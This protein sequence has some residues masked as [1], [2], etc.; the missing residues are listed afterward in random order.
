MT[1]LRFSALATAA[2][3]ASAVPSF[4][5]PNAPA[6]ANSSGKMSGAMADSSVPATCQAMMDKAR[7]MMDGMSDGGKKT[8]A[9]KQMDMANTAMAAGNERSCKSHMKSAMNGM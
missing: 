2:L 7:P 9:M 4:A 8:M 6:D 3:I 5:Q 1:R